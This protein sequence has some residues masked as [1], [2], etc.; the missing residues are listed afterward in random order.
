MLVP[1]ST[2]V[3]TRTIIVVLLSGLLGWVIFSLFRIAGDFPFAKVNAPVFCFSAALLSLSGATVIA[4]V[5]YPAPIRISKL[6]IIILVFACYLSLNCL[7]RDSCSISEFVIAIQLLILYT[8]LRAL[9]QFFPELRQ[10]VIL[11][12]LFSGLHEAVYGIGQIFGLFESNHHLFPVTGSFF[13]PG[14][15][16]GYIAIITALAL[17]LLVKTPAGILGAA[18]K[19]PKLLCWIISRIL[20]WGTVAFALIVLPAVSSRSAWMA[21]GCTV[22]VLLFS[23]YKER[24]KKYKIPLVISGIITGTVMAIAVYGLKKDS[25][26]GRLLIWK[27]EMRT[28]A[29]KP[30]WGYGVG[31]FGGAYA[32]AQA[33][34]FADGHGTEVEKQVAGT[35]EYGFND[36]LQMGIEIGLPG[37]LLFLII[38]LLAAKALYISGSP[39]FYL[40]VALIIFALFSYPLNLL[41]FNIAL[42]ISLAAA[43]GFRASLGIGG[44]YGWLF[45]VVP[46][47]LL[48]FHIWKFG[49]QRKQD[50][51]QWNNARRLYTQGHYYDAAGEYGR[52]YPSLKYEYAFLHEYGQALA[53]SK[54]WQKS[55]EIL[56]QGTRVMADPA[57]YNMIGNNY[58][59]IGDYTAAEQAYRKSEHMLPNRLRPLYLLMILAVEQN[60]TITALRRADS[61]LRFKPKVVSA[62]TER[63]KAEARDLMDSL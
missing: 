58:M 28:I 12:L 11:L 29:Q 19:L 50:M 41:S 56:T 3:I 25:A 61:V 8:D 39:Y 51:Q 46:A 55:N 52:L 32:D 24:I 54:S 31:H 17:A 2:K 13:N 43:S 27:T 18:G 62:A 60:D 20:A 49:L 37:L 45:V 59:E 23:R 53:R 1:S 42:T 21:I 10:I 9:F 30:L 48:A 5:L 63:F 15:Y 16:G 6:D 44:R 34:Y 26:A 36:Y 35:V 14:P 22:L 7:F 38:L 33:D 4:S 40:V 57:F 47:F